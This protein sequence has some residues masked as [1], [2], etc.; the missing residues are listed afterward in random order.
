MITE[1]KNRYRGKV[2]IKS[3]VETSIQSIKIENPLYAFGFVYNLEWVWWR[4][5]VVVIRWSVVHGKRIR[6][7][8]IVI[9]QAYDSIN[10]KRLWIV[11]I[12]R[13]Y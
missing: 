2:R 7:E 5:C 10:S 6:R 11:V 13:V 9:C 4:T 3:R 12:F 1:K 8:R